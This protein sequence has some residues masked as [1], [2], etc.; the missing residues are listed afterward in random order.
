VQV[1]LAHVDAAVQGDGQG[2]HVH[3]LQEAGGERELE[4][5]QVDEGVTKPF[6]DQNT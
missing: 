6:P 4:G 3:D 5:H 1:V 2:V